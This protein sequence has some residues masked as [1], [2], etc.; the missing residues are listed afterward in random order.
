MTFTFE[1]RNKMFSY[2]RLPLG[3]LPFHCTLIRQLFVGDSAKKKEI[4]N[5]EYVTCPSE[6]CRERVK[7]QTKPFVRVRDGFVVVE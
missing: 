3:R 1:A 5:Y 2:F 6:C 4:E 7:W